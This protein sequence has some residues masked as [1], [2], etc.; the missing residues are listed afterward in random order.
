[1]HL[2]GFELGLPLPLYP[3]HATIEHCS[4]KEVMSSIEQAEWLVLRK[5]ADSVHADCAAKFTDLLQ[6]VKE[7]C[8]SLDDV[9]EELSNLVY[10]ED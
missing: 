7:L 6:Q 2:I 1:M 5:I 4:L 8:I 3:D 9:D 10:A